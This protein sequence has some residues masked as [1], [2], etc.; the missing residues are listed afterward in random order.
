MKSDLKAAKQLRLV[1]WK[2]VIFPQVTAV[3]SYRIAH[4]LRAS[5]HPWMSLVV[6]MI[7]QTL[8]GADI[9][10]SAEIGPGFFI[11]HSHGIIIGPARIGADV[12]LFGSNT[13]GHGRGGLFPSI[14]DRVIMHARSSVF[15]AVTVGD[16]A[17]VFAH[18]MVIHDVAPGAVVMGVP[19]RERQRDATV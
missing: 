2:R 18:A 14:G 10:P 15:G 1:E 8:T 5:G 17:E 16:D 4:A 19:A 3:W 7:G 6:W 12:R 11:N 13:I 9:D